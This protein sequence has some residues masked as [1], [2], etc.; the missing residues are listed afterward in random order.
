MDKASSLFEKLQLPTGYHK[1]SPKPSL[2][3][4]MVNRVPYL[5]SPVD[6][7]VNLVSSLVKPLTKLVDLVRHRSAPLF[8]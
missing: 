2:F 8:I 1:I 3:D 6:Q 7:V 5:V 4:G